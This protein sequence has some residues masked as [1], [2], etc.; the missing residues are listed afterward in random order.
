MNKFASGASHMLLALTAHITFAVAPQKV[1]SRSRSVITVNFQPGQVQIQIP[2][3]YCSTFWANPA[4]TG[5]LYPTSF[6]IKFMKQAW[7]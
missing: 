1:F 7:L 4:K 5:G 3:V 6:Q 2:T